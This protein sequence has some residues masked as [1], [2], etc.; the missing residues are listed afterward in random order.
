MD[1][2]GKR[3]G[4]LLVLGFVG[5]T[6]GVGSRSHPVWRCRCDCG[7]LSDKRASNL[8]TGHTKSCGCMIGGPLPLG[9]ACF[10]RLFGRYKRG[11]RARG[12][13]FELSADEFHTLT[14]C[15]CEYC[16]EPPS[17]RENVGPHNGTY[18]Y[19]GIDRLDRR[20]GYIQG[21]VVPCCR[22]CN[23]M[24]GVLG[25]DEFIARVKRI[26]RFTEAK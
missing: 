1:L 26:A 25:R 11:A 7:N 14:S 18:V 12:L 2:T 8:Y 5:H 15:S 13:A 10:N 16:G 6:R 4:H 19:T 23:D 17:Q 22:T 21:N 24:K 9:Q 20:I 3:F